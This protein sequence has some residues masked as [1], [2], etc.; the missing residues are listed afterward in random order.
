MTR[1]RSFTGKCNRSQRDHRKVHNGKEKIRETRQMIYACHSDKSGRGTGRFSAQHPQII[2][3]CMS[4]V[5][6]KV[7]SRVIPQRHRYSTSCLDYARQWRSLPHLTSCRRPGADVLIYHN[8]VLRGEKSSSLAQEIA[9]KWRIFRP[10][11]CK[12]R[13]TN[14][15]W[16]EL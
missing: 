3:C 14:E 4:T 15:T 7:R 8:H 12:E 11:Q 9:H 6:D 16:I 5:T 13:N 10:S 1:S 2:H